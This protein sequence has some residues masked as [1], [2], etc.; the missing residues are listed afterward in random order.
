M[1]PRRLIIRLGPRF[2]ILYQGAGRE[3][4]RESD[5]EIEIRLDARSGRFEVAVRIGVPSGGWFGVEG[6]RL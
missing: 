4:E 1:N 2:Q 5:R 3:R 6:F